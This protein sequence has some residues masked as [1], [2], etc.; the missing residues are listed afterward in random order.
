MELSG[1]S[2][3]GDVKQIEGPLEAYCR[4]RVGSFRIVLRYDR[5][6]FVDGVFAERRGIVYE[7]FAETMIET[8]RSKG[9]TR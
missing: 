3:R 4:L 7:V 8:L 1:L 9:R 6:K 5:A 2:G